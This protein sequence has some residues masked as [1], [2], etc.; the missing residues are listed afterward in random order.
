M[1]DFDIAKTQ[2]GP[3]FLESLKRRKAFGLVESDEEDV[4][5][6]KAAK[7]KKHKK[8]KKGK[9][10]SKSASDDEQDTA[11]RSASKTASRSPSPPPN[12][13]SNVNP[14]LAS[15]IE[16]DNISFTPQPKPTT[17]AAP[18]PLARSTQSSDNVI[19]LS[20]E[21]DDA[22]KDDNDV[23]IDDLD[24]ELAALA[25]AAA[26]GS[27]AQPEKIVIKIQY[28]HNY[29]LSE[30]K[31][32]KMIRFFEKPIKFKVMDNTQ[33]R[34][35]LTNF[36]AT[37]K[38]LKMEDVYLTYNDDVV[39]LSGTPASVGMNSIGTHKMEIYPKVCY[40]KMMA[41]KEE[42]RQ[43]E[44]MRHLNGIENEDDLYSEGDSIANAAGS[45]ETP[46]DATNEPEEERVRLSLRTADSKK[47]PFRVKPTTTL[48]ELVNAFRQRAGISG[49]VQLSFEGETMDLSQT[50][51][52]TDLEDE[53][54][55]EVVITE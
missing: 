32:A 35:L 43:K 31:M 19:N 20:D 21:D 52:E 23:G 12:T 15:A 37:K 18:P 4:I 28:T 39:F 2:T 9:E 36:C 1:S 38:Y 13:Q 25:H 24:P 46:A 51:E 45:S 8:R 7:E 27:S 29:D 41:D 6:S 54:I 33:F 48:Q 49:S 44:R 11:K 47:M 22:D 55:V 53:D 50:I 5:P 14:Y 34:V 10:S 40:D 30:S 17:P 3:S 26:S 42:Q 16:L